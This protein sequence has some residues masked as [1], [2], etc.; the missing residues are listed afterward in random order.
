MARATSQLALFLLLT[1]CAAAFATGTGRR[2]LDDD[3]VQSAIANGQDAP[4]N[5]YKWFVSI[6]LASDPEIPLCGGSFIHPNVVLTAA[7]CVV[8][9][10]GNIE[11][12]PF[13]VRIGDYSFNATAVPDNGYQQR[14]VSKIVRHPDLVYQRKATINKLNNDVA[15]MYFSKPSNL[16]L[17]QM[18]PRRAKAEWTNPIPDNSPV[19]LIGLGYT[20]Y[21]RLRDPT[22]LQQ[23]LDLKLLPL[24][25]C[26]E[27]VGDAYAGN[28][29][30][31]NSM[32]CAKRVKGP[33]GQCS[34]DSGGPLFVRGKT[35][36]QDVVVG[37]VS[38]SNKDV[39]RPCTTLP[40]VLT[41]VSVVR[42]WI[43]AALRALTVPLTGSVQGDSQVR[44]FNGMRFQAKYPANDWV[45]VLH[46]RDGFAY[47]AYLVSWRTSSAAAERSTVIK[48]VTFRWADRIRISLTNVGNRMEVELNG[49]RVLPGTLTPLKRG[50]LQFDVATRGT[51][52]QVTIVQPRLRIL[53]TQP[54][55]QYTSTVAGWLDTWV[56][57]TAPPT[58]P[59]GGVLARTLPEVLAS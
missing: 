20:N 28:T 16:P 37:L 2:L 25:Q 4:R 29:F 57:L 30:N 18:A 41:D 9:R 53:V 3:T 5:R 8:G 12:T 15:L 58:A 44:G 31:N 11:P 56:T 14:L 13:I 43:D 52:P 21:N 17:V 45:D 10:F 35:A 6:R 27:E 50:S 34:G 40:G 7:H 48:R 46:A 55:L 51:G 24:K 38:W 59:L 26:Q 39:D 33:G 32:I 36:A 1:A 23:V 47:N 42:P 19:A 49:K 22:V 54:Y